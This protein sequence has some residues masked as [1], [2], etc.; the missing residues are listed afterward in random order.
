MIPL[1]VARDL[2]Q[3]LP[4]GVGILLLGLPLSARSEDESPLDAPPT[5]ADSATGQ[6]VAAEPDSILNDARRFLIEGRYDETIE[7]LQP[8]LTQSR[9][10]EAILREAYLLSTKTYVTA[11]NYNRSRPQGSVTADLY[12]D[13][14]EEIILEC[15]LVEGLRH[16]T[17]EPPGDYPPEMLA[18]FERVRNRNFGSFR[19]I[20]LE[21]PEAAILLD[22]TI[23]KPAGDLPLPEV[24][25]LTTEPH[26]ILLRAEGY[27]DWAEVIHI[28]PGSTLERDYTLQKGKG[29][30]WWAKWIGGAAAL[31]GVGAVSVLGGDEAGGPTPLP[32]P[33][34]PPE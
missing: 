21:P 16:T 17:P 10:D 28:T 24:R 30:G 7:L 12:Y 26:N 6:A 19:V 5:P 34:D 22:G 8:V 27:E 23:I 13:R 14:A 25:N 2:C 18:M 15:L 31:V 32:G 4:L 33:P 3:I 1:T 20:G 11:G 29:F 9:D